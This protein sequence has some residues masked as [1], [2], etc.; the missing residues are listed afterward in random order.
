MDCGK[1]MMELDLGSTATGTDLLEAGNLKIG[2]ILLWGNSSLYPSLSCLQLML[3]C[4]VFL[5]IAKGKK[6]RVVVWVAKLGAMSRSRETM[7]EFMLDSLSRKMKKPLESAL[8]FGSVTYMTLDE[9]FNFTELASSF[10]YRKAI[11]SHLLK[12]FWWLA[13]IHIKSSHCAWNILAVIWFIILLF[14]CVNRRKS[15]I[16]W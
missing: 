12:L 16:H 7:L 13:I 14:K 15:S 11:S 10:I 4:F 3:P 1:E 9:L 6:S 5:A 2:I 8:D